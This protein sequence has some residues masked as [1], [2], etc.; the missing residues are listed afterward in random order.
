MARRVHRAKSFTFDLLAGWRP[1]AVPPADNS[2][3]L[4]YGT[5]TLDGVTGA[6]AWRRGWIG[7]AVGA[8]PVRELRMWERIDLDA[9]VR[10]KAVPGWE[11]VPQWEAP[12]PSPSCFQ[13]VGPS[14]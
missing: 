12:P 5:G 13:N 4:Y 6:L 7:L 9:A 1:Y 10:A 8:Q 14:D 2:P 11:G 3:W